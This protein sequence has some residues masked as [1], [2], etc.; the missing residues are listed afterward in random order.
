MYIKVLIMLYFLFNFFTLPANAHWADMAAM[1]LTMIGNKASAQLTIPTK[2]LTEFDKDKNGKLSK[3]EIDSSSK[4]IEVFLNK[5]II[6]KSD[7]EPGILSVSSSESSNINITVS[8]KQSSLNLNWLWENPGKMYKLSYN[9]FP[10]E[11]VNAHCLVSANIDGNFQTFN[12][13]PQNTEI[14]LK[15]MSTL[16]SIKQFILLG[17]EHIVTGYDHILFLIALL[18]AGGG[19]KYLLKIV[20][21]FTIA[22]S[23][24]LSLAALNI[25]NASPRI[26]ES[27]IAASIV[28]VASENLWRKKDEAHW[29][30]VF[31]FGLIHGLGFASVLSEMDLPKTNLVQTLISFNLGIELGQLVIVTIAWFII[32]KIRQSQENA[33]KNLKMF[34][35]I[36]II[37]IASFWFIQR[38][39]L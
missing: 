31:A 8:G 26:V 27:C 6:L 14:Y 3:A 4:D 11:A 33:Y 22:H 15:E 39:F 5:N 28:Y 20:T 2:F 17:I 10:K 25:V 30:L 24:T 32:N 12:F 9:L 34:G 35:S 29:G 1:D 36:L 37:L 18:L 13:S 23:I 19:F 16:E 7:G 21:A 38:A